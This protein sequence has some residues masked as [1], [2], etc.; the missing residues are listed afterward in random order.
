MAVDS[1]RPNWYNNNKLL[2]LIQ[3]AMDMQTPMVN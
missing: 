2:T 3:T 1:G